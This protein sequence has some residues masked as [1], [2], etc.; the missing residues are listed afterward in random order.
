[1]A[2]SGLPKDTAEQKA[3][4]EAAM[5]E[6]LQK[7]IDVPLSIMRIADGCWE[8][9]V[10]MAQHGNLASASDLEVGARCLETGIW[11][12]QRNVLINL[13]EISDEGV[14]TSARREAEALAARAAERSVE[15]L[16]ILESRKG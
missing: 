15:V 3:A 9:L 1:L 4:R 16:K 6:G 13:G 8:A 14:R 11:G 7:A 5:Q 10:E 2:A 12:A